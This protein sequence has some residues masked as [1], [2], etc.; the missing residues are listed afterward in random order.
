MSDQHDLL[1][2]LRAALDAFNAN[3]L[4]KLSSYVAA[5]VTYTIHG[6]ASVSGTYRGVAGFR[7]ALTSVKEFTGG[8]MEVEPEVMLA[9]HDAVMAYV[10]VTGTR[11][12]GRSYHSHQA[13]LYRFRDGKLIEGQ[14]MPVDQRAFEDFFR[15]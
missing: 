6:R 5:D 3:D 10:R 2:I 11:T 9:G 8:T 4:E 7:R 13:Y 15:V 14:T 1:A 12:D